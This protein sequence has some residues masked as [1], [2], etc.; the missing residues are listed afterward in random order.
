MKQYLK[1]CRNIQ[2]KLKR[3]KMS[4]YYCP[5][6]S[7]LYQI[8]RQR[9]DGV[10]ICGQCGDP[11]VRVKFI[12]PTQIFALIAAIAIISPLIVTLIVFIQEQNREFQTKPLPHLEALKKNS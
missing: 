3:T 11:L 9:S 6:C 1:Q 10:M 8:H 2:I 4:K 5:Y 12:K 7:P